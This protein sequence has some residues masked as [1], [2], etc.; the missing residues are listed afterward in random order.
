MKRR[1]TQRQQSRQ[2][3]QQAKRLAKAKSPTLETTD[4]LDS[5]GPKQ[6]VLIAHY[7]T[8]LIVENQVG[9]HFRCKARQ[10]LG[11]LV[12]GD[13]VIWQ[14][15]DDDSGVVI[16]C[17]DRRST[18]TK[19]DKRSTKPIV[20][21]VDLILIVLAFEPLPHKT[22]LDRYLIMAKSLNL[23]AII[24]LNKCDLAQNQNLATLREK[25][26][27]YEKI[28]YTCIEVSSKTRKGLTTLEQVLKDKTAVMM[29]QSGTG[30]SSLLNAL[31]PM[32]GALTQELSHLQRKGR[33]TTSA[34][35]L[36]HLP[37]G[38]HLID[39]PGIHEFNLS[40][41][42][43]DTI[44][45]GFVEFQPFLN[46]CKFRN[47]QHVDEPGCALHEAVRLGK[48][49]PFRLQNYHIIM[50]DLNNQQ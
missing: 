49:A 40:H 48:I 7:G 3:A 36:Y 8:T 13:N 34:T 41:F 11:T 27:E 33:Q 9:E 32:A 20:S 30:K 42:K 15:I 44:K 26:K 35:R 24:V 16:A 14:Q 2:K 45:Q 46:Q 31:V 47:C 6:G 50:G 38:G 5:L 43:I 1:L 4:A 22:T 10:N 39:S 12:T 17:Q 25:A 18:I 19:P 23:P 29:G 28:G 37:N 21:N